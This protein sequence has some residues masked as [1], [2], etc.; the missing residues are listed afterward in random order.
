MIGRIER[1][2]RKTPEGESDVG[3]YHDPPWGGGVQSCGNKI[4]GSRKTFYKL[5][6]SMREYDLTTKITKITKDTKGSII[7]A[8]HTLPFD[9]VER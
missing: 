2:G 1:K 7:R 9:R 5:S 8:R 3:A 4:C 6:R